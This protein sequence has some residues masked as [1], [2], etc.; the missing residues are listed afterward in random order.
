MDLEARLGKWYVTA[1]GK[2]PGVEL[3][4][5]AQKPET[6]EKVEAAKVTADFSM[7]LRKIA[8]DAK[9]RERFSVSEL[10][11][12]LYCPMG[13][14]LRHVE[15]MPEGSARMPNPQRKLSAVERGTMA[16]QVL[17]MVGTGGVEGL[18]E[19]VRE[20]MPL[21]GGRDLRVVGADE[22]RRLRE[23]TAWYLESDFYRERVIGA[24][25]RTEAWISF[26]IAGALVEGKMDAVAEV[27]VASC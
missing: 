12:Y 19:V 23:L 10:A 25:L 5:R 4:L 18:G 22:A 17:Q 9:A 15:G 8:P 14:W 21:P 2:P 6:E 13:Y 3:A 24:R 26:E 20:G 16:H 27:M 1:S 7:A 11:D